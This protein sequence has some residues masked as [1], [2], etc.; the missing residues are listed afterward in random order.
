MKKFICI[1]EIVCVEEG[2]KWVEIR[3]YVNG[4]K[5]DFIIDFNYLMISKDV[6]YFVMDFLVENFI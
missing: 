4:L 2:D 6:C 5:L 1:K 3:F